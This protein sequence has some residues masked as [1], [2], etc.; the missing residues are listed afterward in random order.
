MAGLN[1][2]GFFSPVGVKAFSTA[3]KFLILIGLAGIGLNTVFGSF[4]EVGLK[5]L[6]VGLVGAAV[7]AGSSIVMIGILL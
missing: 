4:R 2:K 7:V 5:P 3:G 6:I 1:T